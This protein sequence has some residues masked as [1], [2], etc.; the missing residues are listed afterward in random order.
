MRQLELIALEIPF[1]GQTVHTDA[2]GGFISTATGP[3]QVNV[4]LAGLWSTVYTNGNTP[5]TSVSFNDGYN[6]FDLSD[7]GNLKERSAYRST[8]LIH[9]HM[10]GL[11]PNF[12]DLDWSLP[13]NIDVEGE[14]NAFYDGQSINFYDQG[15]GC[16]ATSLIADVVWH[17][18]GH[19]INGY[20]Y[21]SL[22]ANFNNG[23]MNEG[24]AD[25]WAMSL[26][27]IAERASHRQRGRDHVYDEDPKVY[28]ED[29]QAGVDSESFV[30]RGTIHTCH[31]DWDATMALFIDAYPGLQATAPNGSEYRST[32]FCFDVCVRTMTTAICPTT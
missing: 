5:S 14:C 17:E 7:L 16:N 23:A 9:D 21:N 15:G 32:R 13:T 22:N 8:I 25:I 2:D 3:Q 24:Y 1:A 26:G 12:T 27:D 10:K 11:M 20:F 19:G 18:Y 29:L 28:P 30:V 4:E 6:A 31:G